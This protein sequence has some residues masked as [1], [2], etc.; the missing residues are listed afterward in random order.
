VAFLSSIDRYLRSKNYP[1]TALK[2]PNFSH[3][4]AALKAKC[5]FLKS[6]G[7]GCKP[8][9]AEELTDNDI[10]KLF[11]HGQL[12]HDSAYQIVNLLHVTFSLVLGMRGGKEQ[13]ELKWGGH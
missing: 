1:H 2:N 10:D 12:G 3:T 13:K 4:N 7:F 8:R 5:T 11:E 9:E 6:K